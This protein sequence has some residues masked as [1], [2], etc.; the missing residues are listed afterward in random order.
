MIYAGQRP[1][2]A[3]KPTAGLAALIGLVDGLDGDRPLQPVIPPLVHHAHRTVAD[4]LPDPVVANG[5]QHGEMI[6]R[7]RC[8]YAVELS[9]EGP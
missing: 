4:L 9:P 6:A 7:A 2:F 5:F 3:P 1:R 8:S